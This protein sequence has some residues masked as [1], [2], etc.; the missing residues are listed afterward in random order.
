MLQHRSFKA[1]CFLIV[2]FFVF[3]FFGGEYGRAK[4]ISG[5]HIAHAAGAE[6]EAAPS[7]SPSPSPAQSDGETQT[8]PASAAPEETAEEK[9]AAP[10]N[11]EETEDPLE[12]EEAARRVEESLSPIFVI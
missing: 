9:P 11:T 3:A 1:L 4:Y 8:P 2:F 7:A 5:V 6:E 10:E 12:A